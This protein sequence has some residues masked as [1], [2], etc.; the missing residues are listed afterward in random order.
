MIVP[1]LPTTTQ[2]SSWLQGILS[3]V[4]R[5]S[6]YADKKEV[7]WL[8]ESKTKTFEELAECEERYRSLD[9][10]LADALRGMIQNAGQRGQTLGDTLFV[11]TEESLKEGRLVTGRQI[12][13][14][15]F[16]HFATDRNM[17]DV[18]DITQFGKG[19]AK[20]LEHLAGEV[21]L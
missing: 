20:S 11:K 3:N 15:V 6:A 2:L 8:Q 9:A 17:Q 5:A 1:A 18:F 21:L 4:I 10:K 7:Q 13:N 19:N 14:M 12:I 16:K